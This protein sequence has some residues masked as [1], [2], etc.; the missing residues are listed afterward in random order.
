MR[1]TT[2]AMQ[3]AVV[4]MLVAKRPALDKLPIRWQLR[5]TGEV[6][7]EPSFRASHAEVDQMACEIARAMRGAQQRTYETQL[8]DG[9]PF[10]VYEVSAQPSGV[11][12]TFYGQA[13]LDGDLTESSPGGETA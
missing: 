3:A 12:V 5:E 8:S 4:T 1:K 2:A 6:S 7:V 11:R 9:R 13:A 10:R